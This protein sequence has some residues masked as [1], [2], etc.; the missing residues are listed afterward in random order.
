MVSHDL[1]VCRQRVA[2]GRRQA[3]QALDPGCFGGLSVRLRH[4]FYWDG[5]IHHGAYQGT[6]GRARSRRQ[7]HPAG[8]TERGLSSG[9][10]AL[11]TRQGLNWHCRGGV[12]LTPIKFSLKLW[13]HDNSVIHSDDPWCQPGGAFGFLPLRPG[14]HVASKDNLTAT[15]LHCDTIGV[16]QCAAP[17]RF[18]DLLLDLRRRR[19]YPW[20]WADQVAN[21]LAPFTP[22]H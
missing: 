5:R 6:T 14:S 21:A 3:E 15:C 16:D 20:G 9:G 12:A 22:A 10:I 4:G 18:L 2:S 19:R 13:T 8:D 17:E 7:H 1:S 11:S